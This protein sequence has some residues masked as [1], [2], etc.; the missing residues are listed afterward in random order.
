MTRCKFLARPVILKTPTTATSLRGLFTTYRTLSVLGLRPRDEVKRREFWECEGW[1]C[2]LETIVSSTIFNLSRTTFLGRICP[3]FDLR[4][5]ETLEHRVTVIV[6]MVGLRKLN[7]WTCKKNG[8]FPDE[9]GKIKRPLRSSSTFTVEEVRSTRNR[10]H[11][12]DNFRG[13]IIYLWWDI[14][15]ITLEGRLFIYDE[16]QIKWEGQGIHVGVGV[17]KD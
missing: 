7:S 15:E 6:L 9:S 16:L 11:K 17:M 8:K 1:V 10:R 12:G 4:C 14:K 5:V 2:D 13:T 3:T